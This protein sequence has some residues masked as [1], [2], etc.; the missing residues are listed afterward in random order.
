[1]RTIC[2]IVLA[3]FALV[4]SSIP[5][6]GQ[7]ESAG[8]AEAIVRHTFLVIYKPGPGWLTGKSLKEQPL[9]EHGKYI[10][11]LYSKG[12]LKFG[13][14]F[15]DENGGALVLEA[16]SEAEAKSIVAKDPGVI[17]HVLVTELHGWELVD[18]EHM[19]GK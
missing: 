1:M 8:K 19:R 12:F 5:G 11:S 18:W 14:T 13:G 10:V 4:S 9:Q 6:R 3:V 7:Q 2:T 17:A 16:A 15:A